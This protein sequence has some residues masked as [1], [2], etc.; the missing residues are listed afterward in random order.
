MSYYEFIER[1]N[2]P[3]CKASQREYRLWLECL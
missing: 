3:D 1:Y 2:M